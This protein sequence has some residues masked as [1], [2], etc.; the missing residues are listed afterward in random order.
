MTD[1]TKYYNAF[2]LIGEIGPVRFKKLSFYFK[3][4]ENAWHASAQELKQSGLDESL[5]EKITSLRPAI[6]PDKE[7]EKLAKEQITAITINDKNYPK[8][9]K[10]SYSPPAI[11]Y[12]KGQLTEA[13]N[14]PLAVVGS[15]KISSYGT[16]VINDIVGGLARSGLSI[17]S[18]MAY[19]VDTA[20]H[21]TAISNGAKTIAVLASGLDSYNLS[22]RKQIAEKIIAHGALVSEYAF[23]KPALKH[24]FPL[25]NRI[26]CGLTPAVLVVEAAEKSGAL[27]TAK[28][29][30]DCNRDVFAI[31]GGIHWPNSVG[32]NNLIK[33]GA[34][35]IT[36]CQE[37]LDELNLTKAKEYTINRSIVSAS[38]EEE[39]I[40]SFLGAEPLHIDAIAE[41]VKNDANKI[42]SALT[43][44]EM[45]GLVRNLGSGN[46]AIMK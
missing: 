31:P 19:G 22:P 4:L 43:L 13:L 16:Q 2:N 28:L 34:K 44:M 21:E 20:A 17:V 5:T 42:S 11:L 37:I 29:A 35:I 30:L 12:I 6:S 14:F 46:Y 26:I 27:I 40:L 41:K 38:P 1:D 45:K 33:Q 9:L 7:W 39:T 8:L 24:Q 32:T 3:N 36:S 23:G 18:G 15:R 10:E 25:R